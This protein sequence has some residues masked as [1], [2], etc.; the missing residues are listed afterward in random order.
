MH[1]AKVKPASSPRTRVLPLD[2]MYMYGYPVHYSLQYS[3]MHGALLYFVCNLIPRP[4]FYEEDRRF[5]P[6]N[7]L[8]GRNDQSL[9]LH[10]I[11]NFRTDST[12]QIGSWCRK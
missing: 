2:S 10:R 8:T 11:G 3:Y 1:I 5:V 6:S 9:W 12:R 7:W 4:A